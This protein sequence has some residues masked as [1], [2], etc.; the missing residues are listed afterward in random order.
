MTDPHV[1]K[2]EGVSKEDTRPN[3]YKIQVFTHSGCMIEMDK[4]F[5]DL[6]EAAAEASTITVN[7]L[8]A[9]MASECMTFI[10]AL[11]ISSVSIED[12]MKGFVPNV[13]IT[14]LA[15]VHVVASQQP[16]QLENK[17]DSTEPQSN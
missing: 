3:R 16:A 8:K 17:S 10:P 2:V 5:N 11:Q 13:T 7:G 14:N 9:I 12:I 1:C 15:T 6:D 4:V